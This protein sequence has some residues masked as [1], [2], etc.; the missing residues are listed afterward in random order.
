MRSELKEKEAGVAMDEALLRAE[1]ALTLRVL[2]YKKSKPRLVHHLRLFRGR[3][4][5]KMCVD[6]TGKDESSESQW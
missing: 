2:S 6:V 1:C 4:M 3:F 5:K